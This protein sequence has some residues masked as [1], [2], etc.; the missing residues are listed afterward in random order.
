[1]S[2][3]FSESHYPTKPTLVSPCYVPDIELR[4]RSS[5]QSRQ[6][7]LAEGASFREAAIDVGT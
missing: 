3:T 2:Y 4:G 1:M 5:A 7:A 6:A